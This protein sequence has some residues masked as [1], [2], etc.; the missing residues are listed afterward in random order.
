MRLY[1]FLGT[2]DEGIV[3]VESITANSVREAISKADLYPFIWPDSW[4]DNLPE[5]YNFTTKEKM[6]EDLEK[7]LPREKALEEVCRFYNITRD[8]K[9]SPT[10]EG[11]YV[12]CDSNYAYYI[13]EIEGLKF[14]IYPTPTHYEG[15]EIGLEGIK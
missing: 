12:D 3:Q 4:E 6:S 13:I 1:I 8:P 2:M 11:N 5:D 7:V 14:D 10:E 9:W 15:G